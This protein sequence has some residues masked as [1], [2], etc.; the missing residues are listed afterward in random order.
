MTPHKR[1][2]PTSGLAALTIAPVMLSG[3]GT[4]PDAAALLHTNPLYL[5]ALL[6]RQHGKQGRNDKGAH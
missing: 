5:V 6:L 1:W 2:H 3:C 4:V